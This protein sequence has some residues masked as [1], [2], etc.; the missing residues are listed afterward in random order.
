MICYWILKRMK[1]LEHKI[2][3]RVIYFVFL[4]ILTLST[5]VK[6]TEASSATCSY[7]TYKWNVL[8]KQAVERKRVMHPY[9]DLQPFEIDEITGCTICEEDQVAI[10]I[11]PLPPFKICHVLEPFVRE[12]LNELL[13]SGENIY[14]VVGYRVGMTRGEAD[15]DG[16]RTK[17]SNHSFGTALDINPAQNGL[18]ENC[19]QFGPDCRLI[20]GGI[21]EP[22]NEGALTSEGA[23]VN[24]M[25]KIGLLWGGQIEGRQKDFMHFSITGY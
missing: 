8:R 1:S 21:W 9:D 3:S 7:T 22:D 5:N 19:V 4:F 24:T 16:N 13:A 6:G 11:E 15:K 10:N 14:D 25:K 18:Y 17:Y 23:T 2:I 20:R 12:A